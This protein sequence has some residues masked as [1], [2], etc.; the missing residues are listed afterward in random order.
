MKTSTVTLSALLIAAVAYAAYLQ[1]ELIRL[2]SSVEPVVISE[3]AVEKGGVGPQV[4]RPV[5]SENLD[6]G[7]APRMGAVA[8]VGAEE[9]FNEADRQARR[10]EMMERAATAFNDPEMRADMIER[11]MSRV[12]SRFATFFKTLD[13]NADDMELLR[14]LMAE[15]G[16]MNREMRMKR[17]AAE[18]DEDRAKLEEE[19]DF[20]RDVISGEIADLLGE[21]G[22]SALKNYTDGLPFRGEVESLATSLSFTSSPLSESQ[23]EALVSTIRSVAEVFNYTKDLSEMRGPEMANVTK[24]DIVRYFNEREARDAAVI[25]AAAGSLNKE[26]LAAFAERQLAERERDQRQLEFAQENPGTFGLPGG[27][28]GGV[29]G[30][31][32]RGFQP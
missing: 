5:V 22:S 2:K 31:R 26:Q 13:L 32:R 25:E 18:T 8:T 14:T 21:D 28:F 9:R 6:T 11:E 7:I 23:S 20:Q 16:V 1:T 24:E 3:V 30:G 17:F 19:R 15:R 29:D 12:D 27:R 10:R 4:A